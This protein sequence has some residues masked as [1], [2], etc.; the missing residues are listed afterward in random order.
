MGG[1]LWKAFAFGAVVA[2]AIGPIA[3][4]IFATSARHGFAAGSLAGLGAALADLVYAFA[5]FSI[6]ALLLPLL[7]AYEPAIR[8]GGALLL[9]GL[10]VTMLLGLARERHVDPPPGPASGAMLPTFALTIV[11][12]MTLVVFAAIMPQLPVAGSLGNASG[13]AAA[14][15]A[16]S[17]IVQVAIAAGGAALG[18]ALPGRR[19]QRAINAGAA[20]GILAFGAYG[21]GRLL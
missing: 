20:A 16:G 7:A 13:L 6:G 4:L 2:A 5:A 8:A 15:F 18:I 11:N 12:P 19:W 1:A 14:L 21:L 10:G 3:L 9:V 17:F